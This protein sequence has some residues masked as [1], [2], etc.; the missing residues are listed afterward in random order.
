MSKPTRPSAFVP[1]LLGLLVACASAPPA[2]KRPDRI[3]GARAVARSVVLCKTTEAELRQKLGEPS[4]D[5][6][7]HEA[8]VMSWLVSTETLN[9]YLAV[10]LDARGVVTDLYWDIPTEIPWVPTDQCRG[11]SG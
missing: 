5:G 4:R 9:R 8:H 10:L 7:F 11:R 6:I 1:V 3:L 2:A